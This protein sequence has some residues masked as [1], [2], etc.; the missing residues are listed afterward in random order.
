MDRCKPR[1]GSDTTS[2]ATG[3]LPSGCWCNHEGSD[4]C[5]EIEAE[6]PTRPYDD[7]RSEALAQSMTPSF[8]IGGRVTT[9]FL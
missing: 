5:V 7:L 8:S 4:R 3:S 2:G 9:L 1:D 6:A